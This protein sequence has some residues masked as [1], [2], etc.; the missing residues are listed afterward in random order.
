MFVPNEKEAQKCA[1]CQLLSYMS[2]DGEWMEMICVYAS[3]MINTNSL[4]ENSAK[5]VFLFFVFVKWLH[6]SCFD[7]L[8][9]DG[10]SRLFNLRQMSQRC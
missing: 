6:F 5:F 10:E 9:P 1:P 7:T 2:M 8:F 4:V 3:E